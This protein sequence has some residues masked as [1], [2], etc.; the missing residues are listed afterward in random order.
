MGDFWSRINKIVLGG[1]TAVVFFLLNF[2]WWL[3]SPQD[4]VPMWFFSIVVIIGYGTC[5]VVYALAS[6][7]VEVT[8]MLPK[9][10]S[11]RHN[12][13]K[14]IFLMEKNDLFMQGSYATIA[15]QDES[16]EIEITLGLGYVETINSQG[17]MQVI[18]IS[19]GDDPQAKKIISEMSDTK[20]YRKAIKIK[21]TVQRKSIEEDL[22]SWR[23]F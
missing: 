21:P 11:I 19:V 18:F 17:N 8:Y 3:F 6:K 22:N 4:T 16:D 10:K 2:S 15:Y 13:N 23:T 5:I 9:V 20:S 14:T 1:I 7:N 12:E